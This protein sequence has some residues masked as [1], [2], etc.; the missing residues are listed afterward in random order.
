M[1]IVVNDY[2]QENFKDIMD[3]GFTADV[4]KEF[5]DIAEGKAN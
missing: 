2:L 5:D 4:E 1:G 3:Y